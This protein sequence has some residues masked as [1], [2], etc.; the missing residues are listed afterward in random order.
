MLVDS[1]NSETVTSS[2]PIK[3]TQKQSRKTRSATRKSQIQQEQPKDLNHH[4]E[5]TQKRNLEPLEDSLS[6]VEIINPVPTK[7]VRLSL[8]NILSD[9]ETTS[10]NPVTS[11]TSPNNHIS[12]TF[13]HDMMSSHSSAEI[14]ILQNHHMQGSLL[15]KNQEEIR[16]EIGDIAIPTQFQS[17]FEIAYWLAN[18]K[19]ILDL[20]VNI[21]NGMMARTDNNDGS[22]SSSQ[23]FS[24]EPLSTPVEIDQVLKINTV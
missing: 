21:R 23:Q 15:Q 20:A 6:D 3:K 19:R 7:A 4:T 12:T 8:P 22:A 10:Q 24:Y 17:E 14:Q 11:S 13:Q 9:D 1:L 5:R 16:Q 18:H 2:H